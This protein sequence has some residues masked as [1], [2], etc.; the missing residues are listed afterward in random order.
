M[1]QHR[2]RRDIDQ[3]R[4]Q[5]YSVHEQTQG[6]VALYVGLD[7]DG[8]DKGEVQALWVSDILTRTSAAGMVIQASLEPDVRVSDR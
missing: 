4:R 6:I 3:E 2:R 1:A 8:E 5:T 7:E